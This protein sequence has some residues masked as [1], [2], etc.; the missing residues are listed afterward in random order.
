MKKRLVIIGN[1]GAARECYWLVRDIIEQT[2]DLEL[3]G[4]LAFEGNPGNLCELAEYSMGSDEEYRAEQGDVFAIG[5]GLPALRLKAFRKWKERGAQFV[6]L[7][8]PTVRLIGEVS[9]GEANILACASC[10]SCNTSIGD[11]NYLNGSVVIGHDVHIGDANFFGPFSMVLGN[12]AVGTANS[13]GVRAVAMDKAVIGDSNIIAP[14]AYVYKGCG[15]GC[16]M[17]GNPALNID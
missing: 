15:N 16:R 7:I 2:S 14:G 3:K 13:F 5:I 4:F 8:H 11:A 6:N 9:L 17:H 10:I 12:A 1:A